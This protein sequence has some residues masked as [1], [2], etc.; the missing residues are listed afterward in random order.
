MENHYALFSFYD[1]YKCLTR[2]EI[3]FQVK[4]DGEFKQLTEKISGVAQLLKLTPDQFRDK[5]HHSSPEEKQKLCKQIFDYIVVVKSIHQSQPAEDGSVKDEVRYRAVLDVKIQ[6]M[7]E[8]IELLKHQKQKMRADEHDLIDTE[9]PQVKPSLGVNLNVLAECQKHTQIQIINRKVFKVTCYFVNNLKNIKL[10]PLSQEKQFDWQIIYV[11]AETRTSTRSVCMAVT[12]KDL[13]ELALQVFQRQHAGDKKLMK[14][15][16]EILSSSVSRKKLV[17]FIVDAIVLDEHEQVLR[18]SISHL[19]S[20]MS[21][22]ILLSSY[23]KITGGRYLPAPPQ[24]DPEMSG[25]TSS[26][27]QIEMSRRM[28]VN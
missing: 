13:I 6:P 5:M 17:E 18:L 21:D 4:I 25:F 28:L 8:V 16:S 7:S 2:G 1:D 3:F 27:P 10:L 12:E 11:E 9:F 15:T 23:F 20:R 19:L 22:R 26:I 24:D 14:D